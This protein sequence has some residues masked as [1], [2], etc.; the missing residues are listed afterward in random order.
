VTRCSVISMTMRSGETWAR[1]RK[2]MRALP[3]K[4][5]S[6]IV[7]GSVLTKI[8][9]LEGVRPAGRGGRGERLLEPWLGDPA[10]MEER[11]VEGEPVPDVETS[12]GLDV[13]ERGPAE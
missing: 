12:L 8:L 13:R 5:E 2:S 11:V 6:R 3:R 7:A 4:C 1:S 10:G 9:A